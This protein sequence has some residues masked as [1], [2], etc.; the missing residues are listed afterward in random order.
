MNRRIELHQILV[1][2]LGSRYVYFQPPES[3]KMTYPCIVYRRSSVDTK[4]ANNRLYL[5]KKR[6]TVTVID[7]NPDSVIPENLAQLPLC[8]FDRHHKT[9]SLNHD[10]YS[11][12]Y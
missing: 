1:D 3:V 12:Y 9:D 11:M 10:V 5:S 4:H 6:Y 2:V 8:R 7:K